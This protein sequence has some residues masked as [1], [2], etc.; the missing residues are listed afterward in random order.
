MGWGC[1]LRAVEGSICVCGGLEVPVSSIDHCCWSAS[2]TLGPGVAPGPRCPPLQCRDT[3][4]TSIQSGSIAQFS[5][6]Q[7]H[8]PQLCSPGCGNSKEP[9]EQYLRGPLPGLPGPLVGPA[10]SEG[11]SPPYYIVS[12]G[13]NV[14]SE[15]W[16]QERLTM[17]TVTSSWVT[18]VGSPLFPALRPAAEL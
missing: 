8:Q 4:I 18:W 16:I 10:N 17:V 6:P 2:V 13:M 7:G 5:G 12:L 15:T 11:P 9:S 3:R 1:H 14:Q